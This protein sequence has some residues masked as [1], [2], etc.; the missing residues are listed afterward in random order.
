MAAKGS[1]GAVGT[2][3]SASHP[4]CDPRPLLVHPTWKPAS[5]NDC[6]EMKSATWLGALNSTSDTAEDAVKKLPRMQPRERKRQNQREFE[7]GPG[8]PSHRH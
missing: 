1:E 8:R 5:L 4:G 7:G 3:P 6:Y 2:E